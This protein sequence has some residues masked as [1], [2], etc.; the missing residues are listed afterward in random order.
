MRMVSWPMALSALPVLLA[1]QGAH[2]QTA[3]DADS[4]AGARVLF[5]E[6]LHDED[7]GRF[8]DALAKFERVRA[9]RDTAPIEYRIGTCHEG[10]GEL[11]KAFGAYTAAEALGANDPR[12]DDVVRAASER[13]Q[14]LGKRVARLTIL[15]PGG[16]ADA[17]VRIDDVVV[18]T[19][20]LPGPLP[21]LPGRHAV[22]AT[23]AGHVPFRSEIALA[24]GAV[25]SLTVDLPAQDANAPAP[26][27]GNDMKS[28]ISRGSAGDGRPAAGWVAI[29][30][31]IA[32]GAAASILFVLR[33]DDIDELNRACP[34]GRCP[35]GADEQHLRAVRSRALVEGPVAVGCGV[36]GV[37]AAAVGIYLVVGARPSGSGAAVGLVPVGNGAGA[38]VAVTGAMP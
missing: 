1:V 8:A 4:L 9:V 29:G 16:P 36:A 35:V 37:A 38:M 22:R 24:E 6:A 11:D 2:A 7:A 10:L 25:V 12:S 5:A 23:S 20:Q 30:G 27:M 17:E 19:S 26:P 3:G 31:A 21:L 28:P 18:P 34:G 14:F 15:V 33:E 32:L 13:L